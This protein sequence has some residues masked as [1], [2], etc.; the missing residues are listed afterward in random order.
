[1]GRDAY[2]ASMKHIAQFGY[3]VISTDYVWNA[4]DPDHHTIVEALEA[5]IDVVAT[6]APAEIS[7][8]LDSDHGALV[9]HGLGGKGAMWAA[10]EGV[11]NL[12]ALALWDPIDDDQGLFSSEARPSV[13]PEL[14][15][16]LDIPSLHL[17]AELGRTGLAPCTPVKSNACRFHEAVPS[18]PDTW[19]A[20]LS[21]FGHLQ[22]ADAYTCLTCLSCARGGSDNHEDRQQVVRGMTVALLEHTLKGTPG[23]E[24]FLAGN[25]REALETA[26]RLLASAATLDFCAEE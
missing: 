11:T 21:D 25:Q 20:V 12:G 7:D 26:G 15:A 23:Y 3:V 2:E 14:M 16:A 6:E 5:A 10:L 24:T 17:A 13:T 4:L 18:G 22:F 9:G 8:I 1:M 19:L